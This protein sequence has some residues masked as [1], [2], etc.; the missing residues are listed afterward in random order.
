MKRHTVVNLALGAALSSSDIEAILD[1][2]DSYD[3]PIAVVVSAPKGV[4]RRLAAAADV[5]KLSKT[6]IPRLREEYRSLAHGFG[7]P[8]AAVEAARIQIERRLSE[9]RLL[10]DADKSLNDR[11]AR[12][13]AMGGRLSAIGVALALISIGRPAP[14]IEPG[15]LGLVARPSG[16]GSRYAVADIAASATRI[17]EALA[18]LDAA[19]VPGSYGIGADGNHYLFARGDSGH[20]A[21]AIAACLGAASRDFRED[22]EAFALKGARGLA[23]A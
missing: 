10:M 8:L 16:D 15:R 18:S 14:V 21:A 13:I 7:A 17:R 20:G 23:L 5:P 11:R 4:V 12:I 22:V 19:V 6:L 9:L 1:I 3:S 2:L